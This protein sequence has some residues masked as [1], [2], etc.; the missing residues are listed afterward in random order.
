[1]KRI[2]VVTVARSDYG[3]YQPVLAALAAR[4]VDPLLVVAGMH[5]EEEF[6]STVDAIEA[7]GWTI[8]ARVPMSLQAD[9]PVGVADAIGTGV[10]G[11]ARAFEEIGPELV[12]VLGDRY[13][14]LAA[15]TAALPL[16]IPLAHIHGGESTEGLIDEAIRHSITKMSHVHFAA[17]EL[18][19]RRIVQMGE[20][21]WR[22][23]E[24][25][26]PGLDAIRTH[27]PLGDAQVDELLGGS[28]GER[29]LLV[30]YHPVT[31]EPDLVERRVASLLEALDASGLDLLFTA[32]NADTRTRTVARALEA[33]AADRP[34]ALVV[35]SLGP[36]Y[37]DVLGRAVAMVGNSSSGLIE[38]A[39]FGLPVVNVGI[40]QQGRVRAANVID[41]G[42]EADEI[43]A[44]IRRATAPS[45]RTSLEGLVNPYGDGH[46]A[47]R[48]A[49]VLVPLEPSPDLLVKRFHDLP[50]AG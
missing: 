40:R 43:L 41:V 15:A 11:F 12:V 9:D 3:I 20:E 23:H 2:A 19:A 14:M 47:E 16:T 37:F 25:G 26:A 22:V 21:P 8:A 45:F 31:L 4:G 5:L 24:V 28:M 44:G 46:A 29:R 32:P 49:D 38:A 34:N 39:S 36:A 50:A 18:Y 6:G 10:E 13:E 27:E 42:N 33:F 35:P 1:V 7:N 48:I 30:T 17:T